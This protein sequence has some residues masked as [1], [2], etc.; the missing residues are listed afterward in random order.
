M[1]KRWLKTLK[2]SKK[3]ESG[4]IKFLKT[5]EEP[6]KAFFANKRL[7]G[8]FLFVLGLLIFFFPSVYKQYISFENK[9]ISQRQELKLMVP[10]TA[11]SSAVV[12]RGPIRPASDLLKQ[13][14]LPSEIPKKIIIPSLLIDLPVEPAMIAGDTWELS[15]DTASF[16]LGST[17]LGKVGN[18]VIFAHSKR[19]LFG[20]LRNI[21]KGDKVY[22]LTQDNWF[23]YEVKEIKTVLPSQI[24]VIAPTPDET[25]TLYTCSG[26]A[27]SK[28]LIVTAKKI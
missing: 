21:K 4:L 7:L 16:G 8:V 23:A 6:L 18:T 22:V 3:R 11:S 17:P 5:F 28:R 19:H 1:F 2:L 10:P 27:D 12:D 24:E 9:R 13:A 25:L 14:Y 15:E 26:F 20:P